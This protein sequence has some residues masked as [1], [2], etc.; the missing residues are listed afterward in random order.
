MSDLNYT[1][2]EMHAIVAPLVG[3]DDSGD[4]LTAVVVVAVKD[5]SNEAGFMVRSMGDS[6]SS[7]FVA[8]MLMETAQGLYFGRTTSYRETNNDS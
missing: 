5:S 2:G 6:L 7:N 8:Q 3:V 1:A 4:I